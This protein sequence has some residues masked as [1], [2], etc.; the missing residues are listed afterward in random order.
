[1]YKVEQLLFKAQSAKGGGK[2]HNVRYSVIPRKRSGNRSKGKG[3]SVRF[4][5]I[6][7][8]RESFDLFGITKKIP[9]KPE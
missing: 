3:H 1:V 7:A 5:V 6:P 8:C 4:S 9:D 2:A